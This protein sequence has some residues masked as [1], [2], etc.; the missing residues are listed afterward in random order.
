MGEF[1][2]VVFDR[3]AFLKMLPSMKRWR[4]QTFKWT[5][6]VESEAQIHFKK[7]TQI[8]LDRLH[9]DTPLCSVG[10]LSGCQTW[11]SSEMNANPRRRKRF[12]S[13]FYKSSRYFRV[14][15]EWSWCTSLKFPSLLG[16][17]LYPGERDHK[18]AHRDVSAMLTVAKYTIKQK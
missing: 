11:I 3:L 14:L 2:R 9:L 12:L 8:F 4:S 7:T 1:P 17:A 6:Q 15:S 5:G 18:S 16:P 13:H 10:L